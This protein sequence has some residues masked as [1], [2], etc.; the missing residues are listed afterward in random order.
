[1]LEEKQLTKVPQNKIGHF[2]S[3]KVHVV[4]YEY[5]KQVSLHTRKEGMVYIWMGAK[6]KTS[7]EKVTEQ[8]LKQLSSVGADSE[9][10]SASMVYNFKP[11][12]ACISLATVISYC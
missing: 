6:V 8:V 1:M 4:H 2:Y 12:L 11:E 7:R 3:D 9:M 5:E 10:V